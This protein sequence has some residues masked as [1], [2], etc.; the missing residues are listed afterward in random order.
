MPNSPTWKKL[1][2]GLLLLAVLSAAAPASPVPQGSGPLDQILKALSTY[3]GEIDS[4]AYWQL[5]EYVY[6]RKDDAAARAECEARLLEFLGTKATPVAK[7]A[8]CR[9]LRLIGS[10]KALPVLQSM[11]LDKDTAD[12]ALYALQKMPG[13]AIDK[14]LAATLGK[15][16][17]PVRTAIITVLGERGSQDAVPALAG[18]LKSGGASSVAAA[19]ALGV[20]GGDA[21]ANALGA[22]ISGASGEFKQSLAGALLR[23]AEK[24]TAARKASSAL[25][26]YDKLL[27]DKTLPAAVRDAATIGKLSTIVSG[28]SVLLLEQL[29]SPDPRMQNAALFKIKD[30][31]RP[32]A[33]DPLCKLLPSLSENVQIK[34]LSALAG[35]PRDKVLKSVLESARSNSAEVR[36]AALQALQVLGDAD[37][38]T[39]LAET[40]SKARGTEQT[41][42]REALALIKGRGVDD[43]IVAQ[44]GKRPWGDIEAE[45]LLAAA[46]RRIYTAKSMAAAGLRAESARVRSQS[47]RALRMIGTPSDIPAVLDMMVKTGDDSER[48]DCEA[49]IAALAQK[50]ANADGRSNMVKN[51]LAEEK[52]PATR[53]KLLPVL[54][55]IG[56]DSS[57]PVLRVDLASRDESLTDAAA[58]AI[59]AW[60]TVAA[61][62]DMAELARRSNSETHRLLAIQGLIRLV[63][64]ERFR[65]ADAAVSD[66]RLAYLLAGRPEEKKLILGILPRFPCPEAL[67][68]AGMLL[69][70]PSVKAEAQAAIDKIKPRVTDR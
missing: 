19:T 3:N 49:T 33:V 59:A 34:L 10:E 16:E 47:L 1:G 54:S 13:A 21:A 68:L 5:R 42:A 65:K 7:M 6:A 26:V 22:A 69:G 8:V 12:P 38:V 61:R 39:F 9:H 56:D 31:I 64:V 32:E 66:L 43:T 17:E 60:P 27:A 50:I 70:D 58:R 51:R 23:C 30:V 41:T 25:A 62:D 53:A 18:L 29:K 55:R 44:L 14:A 48:G 35:Y 15:T 40:A 67:D 57:L 63:G 28:A 20:I 37:S 24:M 36:I 52:D 45:L 11:L 2:H 46:N 4:T